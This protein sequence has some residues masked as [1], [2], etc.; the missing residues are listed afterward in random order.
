MRCD[1]TE[2]SKKTPDCNRN[3]GEGLGLR[4]GRRSPPVAGAKSDRHSETVAVSSDRVAYTRLANRLYA[5]RTIRHNVLRSAAFS[6]IVPVALAYLG[7]INLGA[8]SAML[9]GS[10]I[11]VCGALWAVARF[12]QRCYS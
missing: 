6:L 10:F 7:A 3:E 12:T 4:V 11:T 9:T 2:R 5:R 1:P 8:M